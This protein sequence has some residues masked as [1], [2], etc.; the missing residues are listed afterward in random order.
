MIYSKNNTS[1]HFRIDLGWRCLLTVLAAS[2]ALIVILIC[3]FLVRESWPALSQLGARLFTD[4]GWFPG[5]GFVAGKFNQTPMILSSLLATAGA[6]ALVA[7]LGIAC[8]LF[9]TYYAPASVAQV[10]R[11]LVEVLAGIPSVVYGF[12]GLSVVVP[13]LARWQ[14]PGQSLLAAVLILA[15][16]ILPTV[17]LL[18]ASVLRAVPA[19]HVQACAALGLSRGATLRR[20]VLPMARGGLLAALLLA[21][22][23]AVGE[24]MAVVMVAGNVIQI[25]QSVFDPVR[26][27]TA[28]IA[29][30]LGYAMADHR[31]ALFV[32]GLLLMSLIAVLLFVARR[33]VSYAHD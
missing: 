5:D 15:L 20:V 16:M 14:P 27:L 6:L 18:S 28:N 2:A 21:L 7:P 12:W 4:S 30:E 24:T 32:S 13:W 17:V 19:Q 22:G 23:R 10:F 3:V 8:A 26:V 31:A 1:Y 33:F 25:P 9:N 11:H 29:L